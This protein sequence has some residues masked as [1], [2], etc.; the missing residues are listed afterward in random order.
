[1]HS[2][3]VMIF[4]EF[5]FVYHIAFLLA[6]LIKMTILFS[7]TRTSGYN[8]TTNWWNVFFNEKVWYIY[9]NR[10]HFPL[11]LSLSLSLSLSLFFSLIILYIHLSVHIWSIDIRV[12][13]IHSRS[14]NIVTGISIR[15]PYV[16]IR[17]KVHVLALKPLP[18]IPSQNKVISWSLISQSHLPI[19][20]SL[21]LQ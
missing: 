19:S 3:F 21:N 18:W 13:S 12:S 17:V 11:P 9:S 16:T 7:L 4:F 5:V 15:Q 10:C 20:L 1:M 2:M 14:K 8:I 6:A